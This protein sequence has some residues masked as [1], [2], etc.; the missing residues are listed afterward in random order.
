[1]LVFDGREKR[2]QRVASLEQLWQCVR[3]RCVVLLLEAARLGEGVAA[4]CTTPSEYITPRSTFPLFDLPCLS[5]LFV[6]PASHAQ[7]NAYP[8]LRQP[9]GVPNRSTIR[10]S[11]HLPLE[12]SY[13]TVGLERVPNRCGHDMLLRPVVLMLYSFLILRSCADNYSAVKPEPRGAHFPFFRRISLKISPPPGLGV[14]HPWVEVRRSWNIFGNADSVCFFHLRYK[15]IQ[16]VGIM[17][18]KRV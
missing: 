18:C 14:N 5:S 17:K 6:V 10:E 8:A 16:P 13:V 12:P 11:L 15:T 1:M 2:V 9:Q 7:I 3:W 4:S